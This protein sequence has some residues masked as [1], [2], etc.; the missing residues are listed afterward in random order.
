VWL[1]FYK[2]L[3][4]ETHLLQ[5]RKSKTVFMKGK[6]NS[7]IIIFFELVPLICISTIEVARKTHK[8]TGHF[9]NGIHIH[10]QL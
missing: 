1:Y 3:S 9:V 8:D 2:A 10:K 6:I 5:R 7:S 4:F